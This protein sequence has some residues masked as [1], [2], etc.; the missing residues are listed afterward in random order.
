MD[1]TSEHGTWAEFR[2]TLP[3]ASSDRDA[4]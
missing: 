4:H 3:V 1:A 2:F